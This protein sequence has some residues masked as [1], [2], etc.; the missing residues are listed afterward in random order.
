MSSGCGDVLSLEYMKTAKKH[1][2]FEAEVITG[3]AGGISS[4]AEIDYA[5]NQVTGQV[6][7]TMPAILRDIGFS[8]A[9]FDFT[10]GG[11][12]T[13]ADR[14]AVVYNPADNNWYSWSGTLPKIVS[15]GEDPTVDSNWRPRTDQLLRQ[16]LNS[17]EGFKYIGQVASYEALKNIT[18]DSAGQR[19]L[20]A[21]YYANGSTGGGE[22]EAVNGS[23]TDDSGHIAVVNTEWYWQR[24]K[25]SEVNILDYGVYM[26]SR[27]DVI[28]MSDK[29]QSAANR[30]RELGVPLAS[31]FSSDQISWFTSGLHL[32]KSVDFT[33]VRVVSGVWPFFCNNL[34]GSYTVDAGTGD[35][36]VL[37]NKN[38]QFDESGG[39]VYGTNNLAPTIGKIFIR[40]L[41][42]RSSVLH[43]QIHIANQF[44]FD[45]LHG[46][47]F[48]GRGVYLATAFDYVGGQIGSERCGSAE[49]Y[50]TDAHSY[51]A[52]SGSSGDEH[53]A[54]FVGS[55]LA[56]DN[57]ERS[58]RVT[59]SK[60]RIG[61]VHDEACYITTTEHSSY[62]LAERNGYGYSTSVFAGSGS[63][64]GSVVIDPHISNTIPYV[65]TAALRASACESISISSNK[66]GNVSIITDDPGA[67]G[68]FVG[69]IYTPGDVM[70]QGDVRATIGHVSAKNL[71]L[72]D[73][74]SKISCAR[75]SNDVLWLSGALHDSII[76]GSVTI[77]PK[78]RLV[79]AEVSGDLIVNMNYAGTSRVGNSVFG[80]GM[81]FSS[82]NTNRITLNRVSFSGDITTVNNTI[83][84]IDHGKADQLILAGTNLNISISGGLY[85][86]MTM[87][88]S[89]TG[90][91]IV[92]PAPRLYGALTG[93]RFPTGT[94][95]FG[96]QCQNPAT[97]ET[98]FYT[99]DLG[100]KTIVSAA[101]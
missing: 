31:P 9:S 73:P 67:L 94:A 72:K 4:G 82:P 50:G 81:S 16:E 35:K 56:H 2:T 75:I 70:V 38:A 78:G 52:A 45:I 11:T 55:V 7:K 14:D 74:S 37:F 95:S 13:V 97:G 76:G 86:N 43:G 83:M 93:W 10:T 91:W 79:D 87:D 77:R 49:H 62:A 99:K 92:S 15:A 19:I 36:F 26:C 90:M 53:N 17:D 66:L 58:W 101:S 24:T 33:G 3:R 57:Y 54:A 21:S 25:I 71:S 28:D 29:I 18:P 44:T 64:I 22:F 100:W 48:F 40:N 80:G 6:Q 41:G 27:Y 12:L 63:T 20:L 84:S 39:K 89:I 1:Q 60:N 96:T 47:N 42:D 85:R 23:A 46:V 32:M 51:P 30:A 88:S 65:F 34:T 68:G 8:P 69:S 5:T 98:K 59:G 61:R